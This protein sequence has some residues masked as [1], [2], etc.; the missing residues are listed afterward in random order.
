MGKKNKKAEKVG[1][2]KNRERTHRGPAK[3]DI[4]GDG[5]E[6]GGGESLKEDMGE[7]GLQGKFGGGLEGQPT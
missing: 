1:K 7:G 6:K 5:N 4:N 2:R 3:K